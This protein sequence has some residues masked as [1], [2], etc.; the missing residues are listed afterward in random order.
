[1]LCSKL[2]SD[3]LGALVSK[4]FGMKR[5]QLELLGGSGQNEILPNTRV[6]YGRQLG[7]GT[8][9][10]LSRSLGSICH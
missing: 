7:M 1:M 10:E 8:F 9:P 6:G 5:A 2:Q 4:G 3:I